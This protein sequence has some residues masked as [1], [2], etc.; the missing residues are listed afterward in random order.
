MPRRIS[1]LTSSET[2][3]RNISSV[4]T[5]YEEPLRQKY[6]DHH[7][8]SP[9]FLPIYLE[10]GNKI[11]LRLWSRANPNRIYLL[12]FTCFSGLMLKRLRLSVGLF[13]HDSC[14]VIHTSFDFLLPFFKI[15]VNFE[16]DSCL[17]ENYTFC[18]KRFDIF[19]PSSWVI[20]FCEFFSSSYVVFRL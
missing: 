5:H 12:N 10:F 1:I 14:Q 9:E 17:H 18:I 13:S 19:V 15:S 20:I 4:Q 16:L 3:S 7:P 2:F 6:E 11:N 8:L